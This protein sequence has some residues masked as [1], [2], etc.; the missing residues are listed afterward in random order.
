[1][2]KIKLIALLG[3]S[4][5]GK[6]TIMKE[7]VKRN[8]S[9]HEIISHTTRPKR[10][11][12]IDKINYNFVTPEEFADLI[13]K[14]KMLEVTNF[15]HWWYGTSIDSFDSKKINIGVVKPEGVFTLLEDDRLDIDIY[16]IEASAK[17]R[18]IRQLTRED[19]PNIDEILRR[20]N[21][22]NRDFLEL[23]E[24]RINIDNETND[25]FITCLTTIESLSI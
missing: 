5:S 3:K 11:Y 10:D 24:P 18:L 12:E 14:D 9:L 1:M 7:L 13:E 8:P 16:H 22:D 15:N 2:K 17:T 23:P 21:T 25:D 19:N 4:A 6:D 20:Y